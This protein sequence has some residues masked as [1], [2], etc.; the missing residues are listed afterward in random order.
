MRPHYGALS[1]GNRK[2]KRKKE[3]EEGEEEEE[4]RGGGGK[5]GIRGKRKKEDAK[6]AG[7]RAGT[8][9]TCFTGT[10]AQIL[11]YC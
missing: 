2:G 9:F 10:K 3:E 7:G 5:T 6:A 1:T 11:A 4:K 8:H